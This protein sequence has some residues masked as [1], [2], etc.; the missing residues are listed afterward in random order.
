MSEL[1]YRILA[2][3]YSH[4]S[5]GSLV[6]L[7]GSLQLWHHRLDIQVWL[8]LHLVS[9]DQDVGGKDGVGDL[10]AQ[11]VPSVHETHVVVLSPC[12]LQPS[13]I[14]EA[15]GEILNIT[16]QQLGMSNNASPT[17][18]KKLFF[19]PGAVSLKGKHLGITS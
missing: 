14:S 16:D 4:L 11:G 1:L 3:C 2:N 9:T 6:L 17:G 18:N 15:K 5:M 7:H 19:S 13:P 8:V 12:H 10:V